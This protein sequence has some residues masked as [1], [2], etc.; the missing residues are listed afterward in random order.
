MSAFLPMEHAILVSHPKNEPISWY[1]LRKRLGKDLLLDGPIH[2]NFWTST[3]CYI[4][5]P[6]EENMA[7]VK[8]AVTICNEM[9]LT[10]SADGLVHEHPWYEAY[11]E[12]KK[13]HT[14]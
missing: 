5:V 14:P 6:Y 1:E 10:T 11:E 4:Y 2:Y 9:G 13:K 8:Q 3:S 7:S 12:T